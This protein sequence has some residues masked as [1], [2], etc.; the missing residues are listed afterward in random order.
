[1]VCGGLEPPGTDS[2][3]T[4]DASN[5][6]WSAQVF[7]NIKFNYTY[8]LLFSGTFQDSFPSRGALPGPV[9]TPPWALSWWGLGTRFPQVGSPPQMGSTWTLQPFPI[10]ARKPSTTAWCLST[11]PRS[12]PLGDIP[13]EGGFRAS[14]LV[15][16]SGRYV[17]QNI[18]FF[19]LC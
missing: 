16:L 2:C 6:S 15:T 4:Y 5:D 7:I 3:Y 17:S 11:R 13:M 18:V 9:I 10:S 8:V 12:S 1:M 19:W 14:Q